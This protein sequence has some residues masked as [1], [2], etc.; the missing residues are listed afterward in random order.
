MHLGLGLV[1]EQ[2]DIRP[3]AKKPFRPDLLDH[4]LRGD[5]VVRRLGEEAVSDSV[6]PTSPAC[7]KAPRA[8]RGRTSGGCS[9]HSAKTRRRGHAPI[10]STIVSS[11]SARLFMESAVV[12]CWDND[13]ACK[14]NFRKFRNFSKFSVTPC[15][16]EV[17]IERRR[18]SAAATTLMKRCDDVEDDARSVT[19]RSCGHAARRRCREP[20]AG[21]GARRRQQLLDDDRRQASVGSSSRAGAD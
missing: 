7:P 3:A 1:V 11:R 15:N 16:A 2:H 6:P 21:T 4:D 18:I 20:S 19:G 17:L 14:R 8:D 9:N 12:P 5:L 10:R 13:G